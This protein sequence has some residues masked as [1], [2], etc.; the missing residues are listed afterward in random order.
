MFP[1]CFQKKFLQRDLEGVTIQNVKLRFKK[2]DRI[3]H[4][5]N[6]LY[7]IF[8][9]VFYLV[10]AGCATNNSNTSSTQTKQ[11]KLKIST[12]FY[13]IYDFTKK[14]IVGDEADV[15]LVIGAG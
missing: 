14:N 4:E 2:R 11:G 13:P 12:T 6:D 3:Y 10:V 9:V 1:F 7:W 15:S 5:K 8:D